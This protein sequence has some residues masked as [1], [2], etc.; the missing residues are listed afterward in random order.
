MPWLLLLAG[1]GAQVLAQ[2]AK[3]RAAV[4]VLLGLLSLNTVFFYLPAELQRRTDFSAMIGPRRQ[5]L[6]F[7]QTSLFGPRLVGLPDSALVLT[8]D[9]WLYNGALAAFNC[10]RLPD[11][12]VLF[13]LATTPEDQARLRAD[14]PGR[15]VLLAAEVAGHVRLVPGP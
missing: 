13:A 5:V 7:V 14:Y 3:S 2:L 15:T 12:S 4:G 11:C 8:N 6:D 10:P 1:R 9:W